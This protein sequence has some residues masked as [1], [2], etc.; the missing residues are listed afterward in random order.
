MT[1]VCLL[2]FSSP[3]VAKETG[4]ITISVKSSPYAVFETKC[5]IEDKALMKE[6]KIS[7]TK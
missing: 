6:K 4:R 3:I 1:I 2:S 7:Q 5:E